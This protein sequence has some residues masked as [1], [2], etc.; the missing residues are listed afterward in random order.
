MITLNF[1]INDKYKKVDLAEDVLFNA[2]LTSHPKMIKTIIKT[3]APAYNIKNTYFAV[4]NKYIDFTEDGLS[5][6]P[7]LIVR[8]DLNDYAIL[9]LDSANIDD[10]YMTALIREFIYD[11]GD[12]R[13]EVVTLNK[14][15]V[16]H[17]DF[18][19]ATEKI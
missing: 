15:E 11:T 12:Y 7:G 16:S 4:V 8:T 19:K 10:E 18:I 6:Y 17:S 13:P 5:L 2:L 9:Y 1:K 14:F 3:I